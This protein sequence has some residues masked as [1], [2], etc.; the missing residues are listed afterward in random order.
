[1]TMDILSMALGALVVGGLAAFFVTRSKR[2]KAAP[3]KTTAE[4][5]PNAAPTVGF[6]RELLVRREQLGTAG[7][8]PDALSEFDAMLDRLIDFAPTL[9]VDDPHSQT[10]LASLRE[11]IL[12]AT[13]GNPSAGQLGQTRVAVEELLMLV[14]A[15]VPPSFNSA[16]LEG[17]KAW[18]QRLR[19]MA[20]FEPVEGHLEDLLPKLKA[21]MWVQI[22]GEM[23]EVKGVH[24]YFE[25][26]EGQS[27]T[28]FEMA[29]RRLSDGGTTSAAWEIDDEVELSRVMESL[30]LE[31]IGF[32]LKRLRDLIEEEE[33]SVTFRDE[34]FKVSDAGEATFY[35]DS[36][37]DG[38]TFAYVELESRSGKLLSLEDW[39]G[40]QQVHLSEPIPANTVRLYRATS[41]SRS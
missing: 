1:M 10:T 41:G 29:L 30:T 3:S 9:I 13:S 31:D 27:W 39:G 33:G 5:G 21:G 35:R 37:K 20:G 17:M 18:H 7:A 32:T 25:T 4:A 28:W 24:R 23:H 26:Y 6:L 12:K 34:T 36:G 11:L 40:E 16:E 38:E 22:G 8:A 14:S 2:T 15:I 19:G